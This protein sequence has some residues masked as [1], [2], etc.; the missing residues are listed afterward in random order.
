[1]K[2]EL[3]L[4]GWVACGDIDHTADDHPANLQITTSKAQAEFWAKECS[5]R[6]REVYL[7]KIINEKSK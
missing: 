2:E 6:V 3:V 7:G 5:L 4:I 1:M